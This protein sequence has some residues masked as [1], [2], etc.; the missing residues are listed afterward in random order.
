M[1]FAKWQPTYSGLIVSNQSS[2]Q[3]YLFHYCSIPDVDV[4]RNITLR[5]LCL[6]VP[7]SQTALM[8]CHQL[9]EI[10]YGYIIVYAT[11]ESGTLF[12]PHQVC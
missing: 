12:V 11:D 4:D 3:V 5:F 8:S 1:S 9:Y 7:P 2:S 10:M 6:Y